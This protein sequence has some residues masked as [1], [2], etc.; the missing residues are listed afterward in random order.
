MGA[1][2]VSHALKEA[3]MEVIYLGLNRTP[4]EVVDAAI[5]ED[6]DLIGISSMSGIHDH[7]LPEL[8]R[9]LKERGGEKISVIAGGVIPKEDI[10]MLEEAGIKKVFPVGTHT[11]DIV[12]FIQE[13]IPLH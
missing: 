2:V 13:N 3:G 4:E 11:G 12:R 7:A 6:V 5:Q 10:K 9:I 8:M 1:I